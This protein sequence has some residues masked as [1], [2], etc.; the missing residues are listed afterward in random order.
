VGFA[1]QDD[2]DWPRDKQVIGISAGASAPER[3]ISDAVDFFRQRDYAVEDF[4]AL[5]EN[6]RFTPPL[7][8][9]NMRAPKG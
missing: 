8:L 9:L 2:T 3:V 4:E 7:E 6:M 1:S 5:E